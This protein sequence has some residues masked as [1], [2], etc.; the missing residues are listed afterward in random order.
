MKLML[1][2][3]VYEKCMSLRQFAKVAGIPYVTLHAIANDKRPSVRLTTIEKICKALS[4][5]PND[6]IKMD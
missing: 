5:T 4:C 3:M 6:L 1:K 2:E